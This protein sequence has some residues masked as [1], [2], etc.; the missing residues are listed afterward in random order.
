LASPRT[1]QTSTG[2]GCR[3]NG[4]SAGR[5][6]RPPTVEL[7]GDIACRATDV[8]ILRIYVSSTRHVIGVYVSPL[9][10]IKWDGTATREFDPEG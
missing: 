7:V 1:S 4:L 2:D 8:S 10:H 6:C 5:A 3:R 9:K